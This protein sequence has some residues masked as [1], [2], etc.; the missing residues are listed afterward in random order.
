MAHGGGQESRTFGVGL[1]IPRTERQNPPRKMLKILLAAFYNCSIHYYK[2]RKE[3]AMKLT[4]AEWQLMNALWQ[5]HPAT[6]R[7]IVERLPEGTDWAYT[8]VKTMLTRLAAKGAVAESKVG[9]VSHYEPILTRRRA[10]LSVLKGVAEDAFDGTWGALLHFLVEEEKLSEEERREL[11]KMLE[12]ESKG[13][14]HA[15]RK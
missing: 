4:Q 14:K 12:K 1:T 15:R 2:C 5:G 10:R 3:A 7:E 9:H 8:T 13:D 6:A 11:A